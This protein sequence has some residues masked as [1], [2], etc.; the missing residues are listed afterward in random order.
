MN[1][2]AYVSMADRKNIERR[3]KKPTKD[4]SAEKSEIERQPEKEVTASDIVREKCLVSALAVTPPVLNTEMIL[5]IGR[6][7]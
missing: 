3:N 6:C 4:E 1:W 2:N 7:R 5:Y